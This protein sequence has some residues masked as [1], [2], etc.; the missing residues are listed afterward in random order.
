MKA[1]QFGKF[2]LVD[3]LNGCTKLSYYSDCGAPAIL[4]PPCDY[5][6]LYYAIKKDGLNTMYMSTHKEK[7]C[8]MY[9]ISFNRAQCR[10]EVNFADNWHEDYR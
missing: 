6:V 7:K 9:E 10:L 4:L 5:T 8:I 1:R 2:H 3:T